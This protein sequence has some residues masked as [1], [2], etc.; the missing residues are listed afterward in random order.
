M[1]KLNKHAKKTN[2]NKDLIRNR[3]TKIAFWARKNVHSVYPITIA[4]KWFWLARKMARQ[5]GD[6]PFEVEL[7]HIENIIIN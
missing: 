3:S 1:F 5:Q 4:R 7:T 6:L 2:I